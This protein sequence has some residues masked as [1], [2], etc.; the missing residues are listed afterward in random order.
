[1]T[2]ADAPD[3]SNPD[4]CDR[5]II[6]VSPT[7]QTVMLNCAHTSDYSTLVH[8]D[9]TTLV[10]HNFSRLEVLSGKTF[11]PEYTWTESPPLYDRGYWISDNMIVTG[12]EKAATRQ[13]ISKQFGDG[14]WHSAPVEMHREAEGQSP[15]AE[16]G[17]GTSVTDESFPCICYGGVSLIST[18]GHIL[19][20]HTLPN[21]IDDHARSRIVG[22]G[23]R[24]ANNPLVVPLGGKFIVVSW[25]RW[26]IKEHLFTEYSDRH[27]S[28]QILVCDS[29]LRSCPL[30]VDVNPIPHFGGD[31]DFA[32]SPDGSKLAVLNGRDVSVYSVPTN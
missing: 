18:S 26:E 9:R 10:P 22:Q 28:T 13:I 29:L 23:S 3:P 31:Y 27:I 4:H 30:T 7:G 17:G 25:D 12:G 21:S 14:N 16:P 1:M 8:G 6:S 11:Q 24:F 2:F 15:I 32:L 19:A 20:T 5:R